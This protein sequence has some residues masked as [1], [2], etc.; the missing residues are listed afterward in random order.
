MFSLKLALPP[1]LLVLAA[2]SDTTNPTQPDVGGAPAPASFALALASNTWTAKAPPPYD[3]FIHGYD[4]GIVPNAERSIVYAFG[5][6][7]SDEGGTGLSVKAYKPATNAWSGRLSRVFVF[8][9]NG[10]GKIGSRLYFSGGYDRSSG[11]TE[12]TRALWAYDYSNDRMIRRANLPIFSAEGVTGVINGK[13]YVLPGVCSGDVYPN[14]GYCA[15]EE[16][17]RFYRYDPATN[18]WVT[19]PQ[20]PHFHQQGAAG[21]ID[22]K[23]Y[24]AGGSSTALDVYDPATNSWRTR[25]SIPLGGAA[26]GAVIG[27]RFYVVVGH[28]NGTTPDHRLYSY[29]PTTNEWRARAAPSFFGSVTRVELDGRFHLFMAS[30]NKSALYTP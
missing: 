16:T 11:M 12:A 3:Q 10:V 30:G 9:S 18:A 7:S 5:G 20:A 22:G 14:P 26:K 8:N 28:F 6:T 27:G 4:L 13:L 17:R 29:N 23:L 24:V 1:T 15:V 21:V 2:C 19:R 25:A